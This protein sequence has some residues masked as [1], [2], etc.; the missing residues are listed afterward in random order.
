MSEKLSQVKFKLRIALGLVPKIGSKF[1]SHHN[2][3]E[4]SSFDYTENLIWSLTLKIILA[5]YLSIKN[6]RKNVIF[7]T[8]NSLA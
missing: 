5:R 3:Q 6:Q 1:E 8:Q 7:F 2:K 4:T